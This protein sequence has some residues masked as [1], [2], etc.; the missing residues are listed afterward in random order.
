MHFNIVDDDNYDKWMNE[1]I[2]KDIYDSIDIKQVVSTSKTRDFK[3][4]Q[5]QIDKLDNSFSI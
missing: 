1:C 4:S 3:P 5:Q 2:E